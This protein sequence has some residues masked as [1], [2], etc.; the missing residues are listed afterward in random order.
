MVLRLLQKDRTKEKLTKRLADQLL[1]VKK[2]IQNGIELRS[3]TK[4]KRLKQGFHMAKENLKISLAYM[5]AS[6]LVVKNKV[7]VS[8]L[9]Q[10]EP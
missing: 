8:K 5:K 2:I 7:M 10:M 1:C 9:I 6:L 3:N 4:V